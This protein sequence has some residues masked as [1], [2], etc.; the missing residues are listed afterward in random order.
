MR[1][2]DRTEPGHAVRYLNH[3]RRSRI[4]QGFP[5]RSPR[6]HGAGASWTTFAESKR[7]PWIAHRFTLFG[8]PQISVSTMSIRASCFSLSGCIRPHP[9]IRTRCR[10]FLADGRRRALSALKKDSLSSNCSVRIL[11]PLATESRRRARNPHGA[12]PRE[13]YNTV[14][15]CPRSSKKSGI[16]GKTNADW[17]ARIQ[18]A[19]VLK[20]CRSSNASRTHSVSSE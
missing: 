14:R 10:P 19:K 16:T 20:T 5:R 6:C 15:P 12:F 4:P 17:K 2:R 8:R 1:G 9:I 18:A 7:L 11:L 3:W 13:V